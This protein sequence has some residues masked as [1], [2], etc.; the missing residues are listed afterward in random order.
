M[1]AEEILKRYVLRIHRT[2]ESRHLGSGFLVAPNLLLTCAHVIKNYRDQP[3]SV[4]L[5][6]QEEGY[7][8]EVEFYSEDDGFDVALLRLDR[9]L[10]FL[11][12][13]LTANLETDDRLYVWGFPDNYPQG[14]PDTFTYIGSD[15]KDLLKFKEGL[16]RPGLSGSPLWN[17]RSQTICG[18]VLISR[19][20]NQELGGRGLSMAAIFERLP[21]LKS[22]H[23]PKVNPFVPT[24]GAIEQRA[25]L[26]D[27]EGLI[28]EIFEI[29]NS[30][31]SVALIGDS[32][33][34]KSS[35]L[36]AIAAQAGEKLY[37]RRTPIYLN[38]AHISNDQDFY[39]AIGESVGISPN[40]AGYSFYQA[41]RSHRLLLLLDGV[42]QM[43][44]GGFTLLVRN[45]IRALAN[46]F[47]PPPLRLVV[48]GNRSL[49]KLFT[50]SDLNSPF[51][52][53]CQEVLLQAW[54]EEKMRSLIEWR[55]SQTPVRF[56]EAEIQQ[57]IEKSK[58]NP[59]SLMQECHRCFRQHGVA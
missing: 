14:D 17:Q 2:G 12:I 29:L 27:R 48:A 16:V 37:A 7:P 30:G 52:G 5:G 53:I 4:Y 28:A 18:M 47:D 51:E 22:F 31:S 8:V 34:G 19:D 55:L 49:D 13:A 10:E 9:E 59:R 57:L 1:T 43:T 38:F 46:D 35:V 58:G 54:D 45:Q 21:Q 39:V 15:G 44:W 3:L 32:G 25:D 24:A 26:F 20:R 33:V 36:K 40:L 11:Q 42:E 50:D 56:T 23:Q 41:I 6:D